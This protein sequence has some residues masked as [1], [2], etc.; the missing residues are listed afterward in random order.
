MFVVVGAPLA[1]RP[2][3]AS[4]SELIV[5]VDALVRSFPGGAGLVV[6]DPNVAQPLYTHD[7]DEPVITASLY[8]LGVLLEAE[9][10]VETGTLRYT[11]TIEI[12]AEDI[13]SDGSYELAGTVL[14][15]DEALEAMI[16]V[17]DNGAALALWH[18]FTGAA[19]DRTLRAA[20]LGAF[21]IALDDSEDHVATPRVIA[22]YFTLLAKR[23]LVSVA[24]SDRML[25]RLERQRIN[26]RLPAQ[27]PSNVVVAHKTG[28]L[29]GVTHDAGIIYTPFGPRV[30]V[31]MTWDAGEDDAKHLLAS[32]GSLVYAAVLEPPANARFQTPK[33]ALAYE[34]GTAQ[35]VEVSVTNAG[36]TPWTASGAGATRLIWEL[37]N[38]QQALVDR[39]RAPLALP[40]LAPNATAPVTVTFIAPSGAGSYTLTIGL[41]DGSG[42]ALAALGAATATVAFTAHPP[43]LV[44]SQVQL[45]RLLHRSEASLLVVQYS[46]LPAAAGAPHAYTLF[47]SAIDP[48]TSRAVASGTSSLGAVPSGGSGTFF[49]PLVAPALRGTY[50]LQLEVRE[51][52]A[53]VSQAQT[54]M[55]EIAGARTY[56]D[57][58]GGSVLPG[59]RPTGTARPSGSQRP[60]GSGAPHGRSTGPS[61][62]PSPRSP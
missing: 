23:Q 17:S 12:T 61:P 18:G 47:W 4:T 56:P 5:Q 58:R 51:G 30:V 59:P 13:T 16:T 55:V 46:S 62:G 42:T 50:R 48:A 29:A 9:H 3:S 32:L 39:S 19:I 40:A 45:P 6:S 35:S 20:G 7:L 34:T 2:V 31:G 49:A 43:Y 10:R 41:V 27:L 8:K 60:P 22:Q 54:L 14:T 24:A 52:T 21:H 15:I 37:R 44:A 53:A 28:N 25:A 33:G 36:S 11:D 57:D 1:G 26:D 38:A